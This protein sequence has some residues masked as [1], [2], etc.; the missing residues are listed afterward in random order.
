MW[1][2]LWRLCTSGWKSTDGDF[3]WHLLT[4]IK[5]YLCGNWGV[6]HVIGLIVS[7]WVAARAWIE[8]KPEY[9]VIP[10]FLLTFACIGVIVSLVWSLR[11][12]VAWQKEVEQRNLNRQHQKLYQ[13]IS[14]GEAMESRCRR[15]E[16]SFTIDKA[17]PQWQ[18]EVL[19]HL[20]HFSD[21]DH[22][23]RFLNTNDVMPRPEIAMEVRDEEKEVYLLLRSRVTRLWQ[24]YQEIERK[25]PPGTFNV[26]QSSPFRSL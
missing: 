1:K 10:L 20:D 4:E 21:A 12:H 22:V 6:Y 16:A 19:D 9:V 15:R 2:L 18:A 3:T 26:R 23:E 11:A 7:G 24:F 17:F 14:R 5:R 13:L 8:S 25:S